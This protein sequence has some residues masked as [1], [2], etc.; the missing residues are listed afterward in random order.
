MLANVR[1]GPLSTVDFVHDSLALRFSLG[2]VED[3]KHGPPAIGSA[4]LIARLAL[5][6]PHSLKLD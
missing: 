4:L 2:H 1:A 5:Y 6:S 3:L